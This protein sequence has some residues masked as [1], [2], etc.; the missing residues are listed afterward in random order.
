MA[1]GLEISVDQPSEGVVVVAP[2]GEL[3]MSNGDL[4]GEAI[5]R[6]RQDGAAN[7][8]IDLR[9]LSFMDSSGLRLLLDAWNESKL[10]D[11]RLSIVVAKTGLVR[12]VL[13]VSGCDTIL[14]IVADPAEAF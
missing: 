8:I 2:S 3:D 12:R 13:E 10:S 14:P 11:R 9:A 7:L 6:A 5:E 4:L 1:G